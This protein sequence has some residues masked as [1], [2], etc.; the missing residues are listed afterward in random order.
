VSGAGSTP[1]SSHCRSDKSHKSM[2][3]SWPHP[4]CAQMLVD[5]LDFV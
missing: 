4:D 3:V 2:P 1:L 5:V